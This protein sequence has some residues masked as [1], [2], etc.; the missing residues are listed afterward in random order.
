MLRFSATRLLKLP[1]TAICLLAVASITAVYCATHW[2]GLSAWQTRPANDDFANAQVITGVAGTLTGE[3]RDATLEA[4][5]PKRSDSLGASVWY[6]WQ[7]PSDGVVTFSTW[8]VNFESLLTA[9]SG[10]SL[11]EL[12]AVGY[13]S[14]NTP[15][16]FNV[17]AGRRYYIALTSRG[18]LGDFTLS[19]RLGDPA[20][21]SFAQAQPVS[22]SSGA[23]MV[24]NLGATRETNEPAHAGQP[25]GSSLWYRWQAPASGPTTFTAVN[26]NMG[27]LLAA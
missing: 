12:V 7:A 15:I 27:I 11:T 18:G 6:R 1:T 8:P 10:L 14:A 16:K 13:G 22:G 4:D 3:N 17:I 24:S 2:S 21:D 26:Q 20:N 5:E 19:W 23:V 9:Y 25:G